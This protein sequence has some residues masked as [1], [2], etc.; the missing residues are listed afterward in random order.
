MAKSKFDTH[1]LPNLD[2]IERWA[3]R[4]ATVKEIAG[5]LGVGCSTF[6]SY[7]ARG[8]KG[9]EGFSEL[10]QSL[11]RARVVADDDVEASL[12]KLATGYTVDLK[13]TF[14][15]RRVDY[16]PDTGR[17]IREYEELVTGVDQ[18]HVAPNVQAQMFWLTNRSGERWKRWPAA[19]GDAESG[20]ELGVMMLAQPSPLAPPE[21]KEL[22]IDGDGEVI[23]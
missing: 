8:A 17:R 5:K 2:S 1:V 7:L 14:K 11:Q 9:E 4:G 3:E 16:D 20:M 12:F 15:I 10:F 22:V 13:K 18:Q 21:E 19:I 23:S 6:Q